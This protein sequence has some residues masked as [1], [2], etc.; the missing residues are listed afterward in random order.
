MRSSS[1]EEIA[2]NFDALDAD[3]DRVCELS[4]DALTTPERLRILQRLE[5]LARRLPVPG[6]ALL[7]QLAEQASPQELGDTLTRVVADRL[8][9]TRGEANRR[10]AEAADLGPRRALTGEPLTPR[11]PA[12]AAA[13]RQGGIGAG[14][15][16]VIRRFFDELPCSVDIETC[17][18]AQAH[19]AVLATG[20]RPDHLTKLAERLAAYLNPDGNFSDE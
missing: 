13:Q 9:I 15:G 7:N 10:V 4:F 20:H 14:H 11:L 2:A 6:H 12:T 16:R 8:H 1:R 17:A 3:L 19:L 18:K 5:T